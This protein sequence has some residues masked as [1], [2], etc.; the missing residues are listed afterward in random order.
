[1]VFLKKIIINRLKNYKSAISKAYINQLN[2]WL[3]FFIKKNDVDF[4]IFTLSF[5]QGENLRLL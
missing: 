3:K 2:R 4:M 1:M 5:W